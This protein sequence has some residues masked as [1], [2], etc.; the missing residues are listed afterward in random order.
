MWKLGWRWMR[1]S[2]WGPGPH[3]GAGPNRA[4]PTTPCG[5]HQLA[6]K[7]DYWQTPHTDMCAEHSSR[8]GLVFRGQILPRG[9]DEEHVQIWTAEGARGYLR[10]RNFDH[11]LKSTF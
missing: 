3:S 5:P 6:A 4:V 1:S 9:R 10:S 7:S 11:V 2:E 8:I